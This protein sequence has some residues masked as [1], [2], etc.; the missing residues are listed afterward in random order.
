MDDYSRPKEERKLISNTPEKEDF[1]QK[2]IRETRERLVR[3]ASREEAFQRQI[4]E[5]A[6]T[7]TPE[8]LRKVS[9]PEQK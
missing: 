2:T 7:L 6:D 5:Y 1:A 9:P 8:D 3:E 4:R